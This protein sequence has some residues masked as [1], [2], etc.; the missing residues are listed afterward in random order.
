MSALLLLAVV[1]LACGVLEMVVIARRS[2]RRCPWHAERTPSVRVFRTPEGG[3]VHCFG[4]GR[5]A[6]LRDYEAA[7]R[8][9]EAV[10]WP[11]EM[12]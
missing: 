5:S 2:A 7:A 1:A 9:C 11:L 3:T 4:C 6:S 8:R 12:L 10:G